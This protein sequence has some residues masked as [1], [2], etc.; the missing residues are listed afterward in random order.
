[1]S[2]Q[3]KLITLC[4][5]TVFTLGLAACGGGGGGGGGG[6]VDTTPTTE[7]PEPM[8]TPAEQLATAQAAV[9]QAQTVV[10]A[11]TAAS[12]PSDRAA[13][14]AALAAA[15]SALAEASAIP[16]N[17]IALL[18]AEIARLQGVIDQAAADAKVEADRIAAEMAAEA[19]RIAALEAGTKTAET[20]E[21][22]IAAEDGTAG[23]GGI[24]DDVT[25]TT[26]WTLGI[27]RD[28]M[29]TKIE[30]GDPANADDDDPKFM[31]AMDL[32]G[33]RTMHVREMDADEDGD[34]VE[35]V[36]IVSTD[37]TAPKAVAF[38][39]WQTM[40]GDTPQVL[41]VMK[42][43]GQAPGLCSVRS[44]N[45]ASPRARVYPGAGRSVILVIHESVQTNMENQYAE[46]PG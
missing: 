6:T 16:E 4:F 21:K 20:K 39:K 40:N 22:A 43:D 7:M 42:D 8:S 34:V 9:A 17:E 30:I 3:K 38:A 13:A 14:Y 2:T 33:G 37:I 46:R 10:V 27:S 28:R 12:S 25:D 18:R 11:L 26:V 32:G 29:A 45:L 19:A 36:V 31:Q 24:G 44:G 23:L 5:A 35:E 15:Q 1:M 41:Y